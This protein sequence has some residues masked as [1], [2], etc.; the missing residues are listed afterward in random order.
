MLYKYFVFAGKVA[1]LSLLCVWVFFCLDFTGVTSIDLLIDQVAIPATETTYL[2]MTF[3]LPSDTSY[4][5]IAD[6][7]ILDNARALHHMFVSGCSS[8]DGKNIN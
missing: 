6:E 3:D 7:P 4:H 8:L 1:L 5:L 2:C